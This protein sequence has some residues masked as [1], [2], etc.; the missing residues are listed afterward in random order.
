MLRKVLMPVVFL[1]LTGIIF[2]SCTSDKKEILKPCESSVP[3]VVS[4]KNDL[5]PLFHANCSLSGCHSGGSPQGHLNLED[6][7]AYSQLM[8]PGKGYINTATPNFS[9]LY[10]QMTSITT[11]MPPTGRLEE[12]KV[13]L[14]LK[15]IQ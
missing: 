6:S 15:W 8:K 2:Y 7:V 10:S 4:F 13:S 12:C 11:P 14:V 3:D 5:I 1:L 9:V